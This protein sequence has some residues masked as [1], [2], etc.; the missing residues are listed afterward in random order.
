MPPEHPALKWR[1]IRD[2]VGYY[3]Q[4]WF[5]VNQLTESERIT[6]DADQR[7]YEAYAE[8]YPDD[9]PNEEETIPRFKT[10]ELAE[11]YASMHDRMINSDTDLRAFGAPDECY[12]D[13]A[14][15]WNQDYEVLI[16]KSIK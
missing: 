12:M 14:K 4:E 1:I 2:N 3:A 6:Y 16:A 9:T 15:S 7:R 10:Q 13:I 5:D 8:Q 11:E